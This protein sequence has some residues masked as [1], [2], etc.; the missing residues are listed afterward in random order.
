MRAKWFDSRC[1]LVCVRCFVTVHCIRFVVVCTIPVQCE[2]WA[3]L[4]IWWLLATHW[5]HYNQRKARDNE[6]RW[7]AID[8]IY[9]IYNTPYVCQY[10]WSWTHHLMIFIYTFISKFKIKCHWF[11]LKIP[12]NKGRQIRSPKSNWPINLWRTITGT[13]LLTSYLLSTH[14]HIYFNLK[15]CQFETNRWWN[16]CAKKSIESVRIKSKMCLIV[17]AIAGLFNFCWSNTLVSFLLAQSLIS[18]FIITNS[19][20]EDIEFR[21]S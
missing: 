14:L 5:C 9:A 1:T 13:R 4:L 11:S 21:H 3:H 6:T 20:E 16:V 2:L 10:T 18:T 8:R 7:W 19:T 17:G 15:F 12:L